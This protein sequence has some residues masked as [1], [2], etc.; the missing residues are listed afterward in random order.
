MAYANLRFVGV[1]L[2]RNSVPVGLDLRAF[3]MEDLPKRATKRWH[4]MSRGMLPALL[5][6]MMAGAPAA[7]AELTEAEALQFM[8]RFEAALAS[9]DFAEVAPLIHPQAVFGVAPPIPLNYRAFD[10]R[11]AVHDLCGGRSLH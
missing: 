6:L 11:G 1:S 9:E 8:A 7:Q 5:L 4:V 2:A 10:L 3:R